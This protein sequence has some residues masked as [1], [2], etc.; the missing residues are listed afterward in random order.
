MH[1]KDFKQ[2]E[3]EA[4]L[5]LKNDAEFD[6]TVVNSPYSHDLLDLADWLE[7]VCVG[8]KL[9]E[10]KKEAEKAYEKIRR[11]M[12]RREGSSVEASKKFWKEA[13]EEVDRFQ[14]SLLSYESELK[15]F[16]ILTDGSIEAIQDRIKE[17]NQQIKAQ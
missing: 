12:H 13:L 17:R 7:Y 11:D 14:M 4:L 10:E 9:A 16:E 15:A 5:I 8:H 3:Y 2:D 6:N 1:F